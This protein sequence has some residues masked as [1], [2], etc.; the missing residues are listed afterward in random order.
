MAVAW[1]RLR[2]LLPPSRAWSMLPRTPQSPQTCTEGEVAAEAADPRG[3]GPRVAAPGIWCGSDI[4]VGAGGSRWQLAAQDRSAVRQD[5]HRATLD[6]GIWSHMCTTIFSRHIER[7]AGRALAGRRL[8][9]N[10]R[11]RHQQRAHLV[12]ELEEPAVPV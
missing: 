8:L 2:G 12:A 9:M 4:V 1:R 10:L 6:P 3:G 5:E 11:V 7:A